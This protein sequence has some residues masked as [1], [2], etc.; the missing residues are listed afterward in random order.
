MHLHYQETCQARRFMASCG[1]P[2]VSFTP[3]G[4]H[5]GLDSLAD[6]SPPG[7]A[8]GFGQCK[9]RVMSGASTIKPRTSSKNLVESRPRVTGCHIKETK[10]IHT[11]WRIKGT[12][13]WGVASH[14]WPHVQPNDLGSG[15]CH[16]TLPPESFAFTAQKRGKTWVWRLIMS[17]IISPTFSCLFS[18][19][20]GAP[21][22]HVIQILCCG[23][24]GM[25]RPVRM[26]AFLHLCCMYMSA[27]ACPCPRP[28]ACP[29][30]SIYVH[31]H[32]SLSLSTSV[33]LQVRM[34]MSA[35]PCL[36]AGHCWGTCGTSG[37]CTA[38]WPRS[39]RS[40]NYFGEACSNG[41]C[42]NKNLNK[43]IHVHVVS[44]HYIVL[45]VFSHV[46]FSGC[47][48]VP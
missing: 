36:V 12:D 11:K 33:Y 40:S 32:V 22:F 28:H 14:W 3:P 35:C 43:F 7:Q 9:D 2:H 45:C 26:S 41:G 8:K 16:L 5:I 29:C 31:V 21:L 24:P 37:T 44:V 42:Q 13:N 39:R 46:S 23:M 15:I 1:T 4:E 38:R 10:Q 18:H 19:D 34:S 48:I 47:S 27:C 20:C 17:M 25:S 6:S 30:P